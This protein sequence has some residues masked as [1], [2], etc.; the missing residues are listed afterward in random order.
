MYFPI[1]WNSYAAFRW[2]I[3]TLDLGIHSLYSYLNAYKSP[4]VL[5]RKKSECLISPLNFTF[6]ISVNLPPSI[7]LTMF[8]FYYC[9]LI[10]ITRLPSLYWLRT[11]TQL[12]KIRRRM[13]RPAS[14]LACTSAIGLTISFQNETRAVNLRLLK[15]TQC[16]SDQTNWQHPK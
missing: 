4:E 10:L 1:D 15:W 16:L 11:R 6:M 3:P 12:P 5:S 8:K 14:S 7:P 9:N 13:Q 2:C